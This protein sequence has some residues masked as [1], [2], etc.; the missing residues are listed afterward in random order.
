MSSSSRYWYW[1]IRC[2]LPVQE[3]KYSSGYSEDEVWKHCTGSITR[4][5]TT[6]Q[7]ASLPA[8]MAFSPRSVSWCRSSTAQRGAAR[9]SSAMPPLSLSQ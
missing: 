6:G 3:L 7:A 8:S 1:R 5:S 2:R 4:A 9:T